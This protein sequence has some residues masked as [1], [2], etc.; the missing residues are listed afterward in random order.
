M[1]SPSKLLNFLGTSEKEVI[2]AEIYLTTDGGY[3]VAKK[4]TPNPLNDV[5]Y[6]NGERFASISADPADKEHVLI[7]GYPLLESVDG[8]KTWRSKQPVN[9]G[10]GYEQLYQQ[11]GT[12]FCTTPY[13]LMLSYDSGRTFATKNVPQAMN[14]EQLTYDNAN[15]TPYFIS[16]QGVLA[17]NNAQWNIFKLPINRLTFGNETYAAALTVVSL[18]FILIKTN[19]QP[20]ALCITAKVKPLCVLASTLLYW[21]H[22]KIKTSFI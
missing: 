3:F 2:G 4:Q 15:K 19:K 8:G 10:S 7:G 22:L 14:F 17:K 20:W 21:F 5:Y 16:K 13:G 1:T 12:L 11:Q 18:L 9:L 6:Q